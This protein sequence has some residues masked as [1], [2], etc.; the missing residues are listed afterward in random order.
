MTEWAPSGVQTPDSDAGHRL[1][2][3]AAWDAIQR[4]I[5]ELQVER[6]EA[7][8]TIT[9]LRDEAER[10]RGEAEVWKSL[11]VKAVGGQS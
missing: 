11:Y 5:A 9:W 4:T 1:V 8:Q 3:A 2:T 7:R 10:L 6:D